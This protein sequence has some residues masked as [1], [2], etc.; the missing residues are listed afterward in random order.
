MDST[1]AVRHLK[2][3][4]VNY[5]SATHTCNLIQSIIKQ[6]YVDTSITV[7]CTD[8]S[9]SEDERT[10]L[11]NFKNEH[12]PQLELIFNQ[13]NLGFGKAINQVAKDTSFDFLLLINPDVELHKDT[14]QQLL[15]AALKK[16][17]SG[18]WGG[19][20]WSKN[21]T[22]DYRHA[23]REPSLLRTFSWAFGLQKIIAHPLLQVS[24]RHQHCEHIYT[25]DSISGCCLL[26]SQQAWLDTNGFDESF[27]LY[28][29]ETDLC[30]RA[31]MLKYTP[32]ITPLATLHHAISN[33]SKTGNRLVALHHSKLLYAQKHHGT[34]HIVL[35]RLLI[36]I[37]AIIR[38]TIMMF[39]PNYRQASK[40][41]MQV[42]LSAFMRLN[43]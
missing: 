36:A 18:L 8:N 38:A 11:I 43:K 32:S 7:T 39:M 19:E 27:F 29:E 28:S 14:I 31:R 2:I 13:Q 41:W 17:Q 24:Y 23:W 42:S 3:I 40:A 16:P 33:D 35:Y 9:N 21:N 34:I 37:G 5:H 10:S 1:P 6:N 4:I 20:T 26:I 15:N 12:Y 30:Y 22:K 25:V